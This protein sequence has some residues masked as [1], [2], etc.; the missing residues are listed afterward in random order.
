MADVLVVGGGPAGLAAAAELRRRGADCLV[1]ER[2]AEVG[3]SWRR[4]YE[5]LHL[6]TAAF[7][8]VLPGLRYPRTEGMWVAREGVVRYLEAYVRHHGLAVRPGTEVL[9]VER[10]E[11]GWTVVTA[12]EAFRAPVVV[13]AT[14]LNRV[15]RVPDWPGLAGFQGEVLHSSEYRRPAP[16]AGRRVLVVGSGN[17]GAEVA[18]QLARG[19]AA[20]VWMAVRTP[21]SVVPRIGWP[22]PNPALAIGSAA[23]P[24]GVVDLLARVMQRVAFGDLP[25]HGLP[26]PAPGTYGRVLRGEAIPVVDAGIAAALRAGLVQVVPPPARF[27]R[28]AVVLADGRRLDAEAVVAATGFVP[29]LEP[30][31]GHLGVLD[32]RGR[33]VIGERLEAA[34]AP[35]LY[36]V[37]YVSPLT[38]QLREI[39]R[40]A[41]RLGRHLDPAAIRARPGPVKAIWR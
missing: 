41:R 21:P 22:A 13:M 15:P 4:H 18:A 11:A 2:G 33:P 29:G 24:A 12:G 27:E 5:G 16:F 40:Q 9:R 32:E 14:G 10:E 35:G 34:A 38:G 6:H 19:G 31:V 1:L 25:R 37:G 26:A 20:R 30:L 7:L 8:S 3:T 23:L 28:D 36:F 17:S 39:A